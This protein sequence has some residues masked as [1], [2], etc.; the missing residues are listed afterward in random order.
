MSQAQESW[1]GRASEYAG[2]KMTANPEYLQALATL[3]I[4][5]ALH[6][7][8]QAMETAQRSQQG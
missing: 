5:E 6:R 7:V 8:A 1:F 4:A 2:K 3:A